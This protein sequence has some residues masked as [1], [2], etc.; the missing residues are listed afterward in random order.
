MKVFSAE[1][2]SAYYE[3]LSQNE[4][5][6]QSGAKWD[7]GQLA[8]VMDEEA[9]LIDLHE[10]HCRSIHAVSAADA[11]TQANF[12][13]EGNRIIWQKVLAGELAPIMGIMSGK[14]KLTKGSIGKLMPFTKAAI[15]LVQSAQEL[16][17]DF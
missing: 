8:L 6:K 7:L 13:I 3:A 17:T 1:W 12:I 9:V 16:E 14:L 5:Y 10:G 2:A 11:Q 15:D 4:A